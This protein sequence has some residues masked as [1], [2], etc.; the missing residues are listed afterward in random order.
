MVEVGAKQGVCVCV[1]DREGGREGE[2]RREREREAG[3]GA[4][5]CMGAGFCSAGKEGEQEPQQ[6]KKTKTQVRISAP[7]KPSTVFLGD[8]PMRGVRPKALPHA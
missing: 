8:T 1:L 3:M 6:T 2:K 5:A 7:T 4:W